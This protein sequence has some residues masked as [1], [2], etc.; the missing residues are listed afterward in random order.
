M[1]LKEKLAPVLKVLKIV[2]GCILVLLAGLLAGACAFFIIVVLLSGLNLNVPGEWSGYFLV[3]FVPAAVLFYWMVW[4]KRNKNGSTGKTSILRPQRSVQTA[5]K[6]KFPPAS[7]DLR[8][9]AEIE[10]T[11]DAVTGTI[12]ANP[13]S[14]DWAANEALLKK[15]QHEKSVRLRRMTTLLESVTIQG[16]WNTFPPELQ[17]RFEKQVY[18]Y[19][20]DVGRDGVLP[21]EA[22]AENRGLVFVDGIPVPKE[23]AARFEKLKEAAAA[24]KERKNAM[25]I[26]AMDYPVPFTELRIYPDHIVKRAK[27]AQVLHAEEGASYGY[28][29][30]ETVY[31]Y[32]ENGRTS[33]VC[34]KQHW[35][36]H[37]SQED[38]KWSMVARL[39]MTPQP[40]HR[41]PLTKWTLS[42]P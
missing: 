1:N 42:M 8:K 10:R 34:E 20:Q 30:K 29:F 38:S 25:V 21:K 15:L 35:Y 4:S 19:S 18:Q 36:E 39:S 24:E 31:L 27:T 37:G 17:R 41:I 26:K 16:A 33:L 28:R 14:H 5:D 23:V 6:P 32:E 7:E 11:I 2:A 12:Q 40:R 22:Y 13:M 9:L 3:C